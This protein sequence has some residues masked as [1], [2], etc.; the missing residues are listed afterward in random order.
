MLAYAYVSVLDIDFT[1]KV[2]KINWKKK[3]FLLNFVRLQCV[4]IKG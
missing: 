2:T 4:R 3:L 1:C